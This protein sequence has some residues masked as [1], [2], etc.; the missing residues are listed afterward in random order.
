MANQDSFGFLDP[1]DVLRGCH[2]IPVFAKGKHHSSGK[3]M[4]FCAKDSNDWNKYYINRFVDQ[5]M[6]MHYYFGL[7]VGHKYSWPE[8]AIP[9]SDGADE[10]EEIDQNSPAQSE[11]EE[12]G[13][14][15]E[16]RGDELQQTG[17]GNKPAS[18][19][20]FDIEDQDTSSSDD[21]LDK[22]DDKEFIARCEPDL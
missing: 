9:N 17:D 8:P 4:S 2:I 10:R 11:L 6:I 22:N 5:D 13:D 15:S 12:E 16:A 7:S 18:D 1:A 3:G 21:D 20:E 14:D 19:K